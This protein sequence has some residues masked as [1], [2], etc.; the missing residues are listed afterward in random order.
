MHTSHRITIH[1]GTAAWQRLTAAAHL[2]LV[3]VAAMLPMIAFSSPAH[4][5]SSKPNLVIIVTDDQGIDAIEGTTWPNDLNVRTPTLAT[6]ADRGRIFTN[7]RVNA[8]CSPTRAAFMTGRSAF[9]TGVTGVIGFGQSEPNRDLVSLHHTERTIAEVLKDAGYYNVL[10]DKWHIGWSDTFG[11]NPQHQGFDEF[12]G[13]NAVRH[14]DDP[15]QVGDEHITRSVDRALD[16]IRNRPDPNQPYALFFWTID[17]HKRV[18][19]TGKEPLLWW[20]VRDELLPSGEDYYAPERDNNLN[21]YRAVVEALDTELNRLLQGLNI[22]NENLWYVESSNTVVIFTSD[23][24]TPNEV[25]PNEGRAKHTLYEDGVRVP[26][27]IFGENVPKDGRWI[28][29]PVTTYDFF[30]TIA[31]I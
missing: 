28:D 14:L 24:G 11:T 21:R 27:F 10:I 18:D 20:K 9:Q 17:P 19:G 12:Y 26:L 29:R 25:S 23:N 16:A 31:D 2:T 8:A 13:Y 3:V 7:A 30:E 5:S 1:A 15:V 4:A 22:I 6:L